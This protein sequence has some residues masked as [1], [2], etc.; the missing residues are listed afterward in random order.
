MGM[1]HGSHCL[2]GALHY[3]DIF[4]TLYQELGNILNEGWLESHALS[5]FFKGITDPSYETFVMIQRSKNESLNDAVLALRKHE[6]K[7]NEK[8][9][10]KRT[11]KNTAWR[12][13]DNKDITFDWDDDERS[14]HPMKKARRTKNG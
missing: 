13:V 14:S 2:N 5:V 11:F 3:I 10:E 9:I 6:H 12:M 8:R 1:R 7:L 4:L